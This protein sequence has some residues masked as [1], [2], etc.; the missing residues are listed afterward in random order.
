MINFKKPEECGISSLNIE[1][2]VKKLEDRHLYTWPVK[3][4]IKNVL[5]S[6]WKLELTEV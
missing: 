5:N 4:E 6:C 1:C 3:M 2:F